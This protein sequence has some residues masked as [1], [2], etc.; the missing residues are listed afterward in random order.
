MAR[1]KVKNGERSPG[2]QCLTR[3]VPNGFRPFRLSLAPTICPWV[4]EDESGAEAEE[5]TNH[6]AWERTLSFDSV[7]VAS[8]AYG[9]IFVYTFCLI[10]VGFSLSVSVDANKI[11]TLNIER[12]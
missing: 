6:N 8:L 1:R 5:I 3:P 2:G 7:F 9:R 11:K 4:S 10:N 12:A